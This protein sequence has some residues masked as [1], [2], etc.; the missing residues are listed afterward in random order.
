MLPFS[1]FRAKLV[2]V[3]KRTVK[4]PQVKKDCQ[5]SPA[6]ACCNTNPFEWKITEVVLERQHLTCSYA[7]T[8]TFSGRIKEH[9]RLT[10][11]LVNDS[12]QYQ[13]LQ[14]FCTNARHWHAGN[15]WSTRYR[16]RSKWTHVDLQ[17]CEVWQR[18]IK[19][20]SFSLACFQFCN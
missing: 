15:M 10:Q 20:G 3:K 14:Q 8:Y 5:T 17:L 19:A 2:V 7:W 9:I 1:P 13:S 4:L 12:S 18:Y 16:L 11:F 6:R